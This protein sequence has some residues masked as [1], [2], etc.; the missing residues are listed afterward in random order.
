MH[1]LQ[2]VLL[3]FGSTN[4]SKFFDYVITAFVILV[5]TMVWLSFL[6]SINLNEEII[7]N[8]KWRMIVLEII[9]FL[10]NICV[11]VNYFLL[12]K[13]HSKI[14]KLY[15]N[16]VSIEEDMCRSKSC[17][18]SLTFLIFMLSFVIQLYFNVNLSTSCK[19]LLKLMSL[20]DLEY[21]VYVES[22]VCNFYV[23]GIPFVS[24]LICFELR[25]Q[26][27]NLYFKKYNYCC[28]HH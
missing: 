18:L 25:K 24:M 12:K 20:D 26:Y 7:V 15:A 8:D 4:K 21:L 17:V 23:V 16:G 3:P 11:T 13:Y 28:F 10:Y 5:L 22:F 19:K 2:Y 1:L 27:Y 6:V 9:I 14:I